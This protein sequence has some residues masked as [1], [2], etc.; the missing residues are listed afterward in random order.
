MVNFLYCT[1]MICASW[2]IWE[3]M[4]LYCILGRFYYF[5]VITQNNYSFLAFLQGT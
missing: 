4:I 5:R 2:L 3:V 1:S